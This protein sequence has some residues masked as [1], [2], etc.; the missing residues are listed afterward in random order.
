MG[1][2]GGLFN[3]HICQNFNPVQG[4]EGDTDNV[5]HLPA[6]RS[7]GGLLEE[8][9]PGGVFQL[10]VEGHTPQPPSL[11]KSIHGSWRVGLMVEPT[12]AMWTVYTLS[13]VVE[14]SWEKTVDHAPQ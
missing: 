12:G 7:R 8:R 5:L 3:H 1:T 9:G 13:R 11:V 14:G 2:S 10:Q 6:D 4:Q